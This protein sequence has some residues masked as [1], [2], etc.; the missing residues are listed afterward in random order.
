MRA[1][2]QAQLTEQGTSSRSHSSARAPPTAFQHCPHRERT[3]KGTS[4]SDGGD[5]MKRPI[6]GVAVLGLVALGTILYVA[7]GTR[8]L[9]QVTTTTPLDVYTAKFL[10]GTFQP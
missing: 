7:L 8:A 2:L 6:A 5:A 1:T 4:R 10:C 9:A 3:Q